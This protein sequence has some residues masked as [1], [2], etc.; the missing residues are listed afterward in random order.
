MLGLFN[1]VLWPA[2]APLQSDLGISPQPARVEI[3][4]VPALESERMFREL[5]AFSVT[6]HAANI[7]Q[8]LPVM[9]SVTGATF[10]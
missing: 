9:Q 10:T 5:W 6:G 7:S 2:M 8:G 3:E 1:D 4:L